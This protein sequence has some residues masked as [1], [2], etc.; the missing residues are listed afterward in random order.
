VGPSVSRGRW[1]SGGAS[2]GGVT[3]PSRRGRAGEAGPCGRIAGAD[4]P[5]KTAAGAARPS[6]GAVSGVARTAGASADPAERA[7]TRGTTVW[8]LSGA[9]GESP[10]PDAAAP[11]IGVGGALW[12]GLR[13][14]DAVL[15]RCPFGQA[16]HRRPRMTAPP[17]LAPPARGLRGHTRTHPLFAPPGRPLPATMTTPQRLSSLG[18]PPRHAARGGPPRPDSLSAGTRTLTNC[19]RHLAD[20]SPRRSRGPGGCL[21]W[22]NRPGTSSAGALPASPRS[23]RG[24]EDAPSACVKRSP[25]RPR[26]HRGGLRRDDRLGELLVVARPDSLSARTKSSASPC[27]WE[28]RGEWPGGSLRVSKSRRDPS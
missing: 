16:S 12:I 23:P 6:W 25:R 19:S 18:N 15:G 24:P 8:A 2:R 5:T 1:G 22:E 26:R 27:A 14:G 17:W 28:R 20:R 7:S 21:R 3:G 4:F 11:D 9:H 10:P 13:E